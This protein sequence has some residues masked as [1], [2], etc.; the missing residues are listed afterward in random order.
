MTPCG[1]EPMDV[2]DLND[3]TFK[4][5]LGYPNSRP[6]PNIIHGAFLATPWGGEGGYRRFPLRAVP[7][8]RE[9]TGVSPGSLIDAVG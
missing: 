4:W 5:R 9:I 7:I 2:Y 3:I 6:H 1:T 8:S